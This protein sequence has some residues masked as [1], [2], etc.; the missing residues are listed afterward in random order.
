MERIYTANTMAG[1]TIKD[2]LLGRAAH[3][4]CRT[5]A[6][7]CAV[8]A[9]TFFFSPQSAQAD[10]CAIAA[11]DKMHHLA[12]GVSPP[13]KKKNYKVSGD[14]P[15]AP[16]TG[17]EQVIKTH[18][19]NKRDALEDW[20]YNDFADMIIEALQKKSQQ[21][22]E[23]RRSE[24]NTEATITDAEI[25]Q[26]S[27]NEAGQEQV[28]NARRFAPDPQL[29]AA[30]T[31]ARG[32][33]AS[34]AAGEKTADTAT[35]AI[36]KYHSY[37]G[38]TS[39]ARGEGWEKEVRLKSCVDTYC[40]PEDHGGNVQA[41]G[42]PKTGG[43]RRINADI[44]YAGTLAIPLTIDAE[45]ASGSTGMQD[46]LEMSKNLYGSDMFYDI[47]PQRLNAQLFNI[48]QIQAKRNLLLNS[49][50][51]QV[52]M[53]AKGEA[54]TAPQTIAAFKKLGLPDEIIQR[55]LKGAPSYHALMEVLTKKMYQDGN[56]YIDI[57]KNPEAIDRT[58][59]GMSAIANMQTRDISATLKRQEILYGL[60]LELKL[61]KA[62]QRQTATSATAQQTEEPK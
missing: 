39:T 32:L 27:A 29:C 23:N 9:A 45:A 62:Q 54:S 22:T 61:L 11:Q 46:V 43:N 53:K 34:D 1:L 14:N 21:V 44:D 58:N 28:E 38:G 20:M 2:R 37:S 17:T 24:T 10:T 56:F 26:E 25:A 35:A 18:F 3:K 7:L 36:T 33:A 55:D 16:G 57:I 40:D 12:V 30:A 31:G 4:M 49:F 15:P 51:S 41:L 8:L 48:R 47:T 59:A 19:Y 42:I 52:G 5:N 13:S 6:L 50:M 60:L